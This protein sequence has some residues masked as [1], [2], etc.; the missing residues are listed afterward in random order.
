MTAY[1]RARSLDE[2]LGHLARGPARILA[3]GTDVY[4]ALVDRPLREPILDITGVADL[5]G[6]TRDD[7]GFRI[8]ALTTWSDVI[9]ADLPAW[10]DG[11]K[12]AAREV[13]GVQ[14]QNAGTVAGNICNASPAADGTVALLAL[15]AEVE[16]QG[17]GGTRRMGLGDF[18]LGVRQTALK[19]GEMVT[20][21]H[22]PAPRERGTSDFLKLGA[23]HYLV[24][25]IAMVS[26][27]I[28]VDD[29]GRVSRAGVAVGA[30]SPVARRL[31]A[32]EARLVGRRIG[33]G[34]AGALGATDLDVLSPISDVRASAEYRLDAALTLVRRSLER[35]GDAL[36]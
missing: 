12:L 1:F 23:R 6:I 9:R 36:R 10:F 15:G 34:L 30:C 3:G 21:V 33:D 22:V 17:A 31:P 20:A 13:G 19:A 4:P 28:H 27:V 2:A 5:R 24:I 7:N 18:V 14:I 8:G 11:L 35:C 29:A 16:V 25:S 32:L 26:A